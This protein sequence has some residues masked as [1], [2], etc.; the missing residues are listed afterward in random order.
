MIAPVVA[1]SLWS[2]SLTENSRKIGFPF[3]YHLIFIFCGIVYL[4]CMIIVAMLPKSIDQQKK[5][6]TEQVNQSHPSNPEENEDREN[7]V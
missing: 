2:A 6:P 1:G 7:Q 5:V 4:C 3:D